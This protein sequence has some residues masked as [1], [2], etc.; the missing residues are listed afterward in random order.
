MLID[1]YDEQ[2]YSISDVS[3]DD[4]HGYLTDAWVDQDLMI[5]DEEIGFSVSNVQFS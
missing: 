1:Y 2:A 5:A 4:Q 3:F